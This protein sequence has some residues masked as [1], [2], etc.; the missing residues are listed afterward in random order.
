MPA[1]KLGNFE[2][3][4]YK[5][6]PYTLYRAHLVTEVRAYGGVDGN[7]I[8]NIG[9]WGDKFEANTIAVYD[10]YDDAIAGKI[11]YDN[12]IADTGLA[13]EVQG[14][15]VAGYTFKV[16]AVEAKAKRVIKAI[17]AD[18]GTEY[19]AIVEAKWMLSSIRD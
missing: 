10:D 5:G 19:S 3:A 12:S 11:E 15:A 18:D 8:W 2:F 16:F 1:A 4:V 6:P 17:T 9:E 7:D 14:V 13:L